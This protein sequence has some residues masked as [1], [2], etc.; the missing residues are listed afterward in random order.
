MNIILPPR[1]T[2]DKSIGIIAP[3]TPVSGVLTKA[4]I[5]GGYNYLRDKGFNIVEGESTKFATKRHITPVSMRIKDIHEFVMREDIGCIMSFWGGLNSNQLLE[6][7][8]YELIKNNPKIIIGFSDMTAMTT[9]ITKKTGL[10]TFSGPAV[11]SFAKPEP[12]EYT[13]EYFNRMCIIGESPVEVS[14]SSFYADDLF[15]LREIY[16]V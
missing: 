13:W 9:A 2:K 14:S 10:I 12:F 8:D 16:K 11:I 3:A 1:L 5:D 15:Y 6:H 4:K 7:L